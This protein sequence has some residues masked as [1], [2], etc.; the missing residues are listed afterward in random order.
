MEL[1]TRTQ[2]ESKNRFNSETPSQQDDQWAKRWGSEKKD[3]YDSL[4][5][6]TYNQLHPK[7][8]IFFMHCDKTICK[9]DEWN[10]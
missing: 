4:R 1:I 8:G 6:R 3:E 10:C 5:I 7:I 2:D 9:R